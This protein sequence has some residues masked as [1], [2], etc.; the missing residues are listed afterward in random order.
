MIFGPFEKNYHEG[1]LWRG[2]RSVISFI[3]TK[4]ICVHFYHH[5]DRFYNI[6]IK[7]KN[8]TKYLDEDGCGLKHIFFAN[9]GMRSSYGYD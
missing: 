7:I 9:T 4:Q 1:T 5:G 8:K 3:I 6:Y 2:S